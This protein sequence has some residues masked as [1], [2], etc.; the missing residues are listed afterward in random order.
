MK[1][2]FQKKKNKN[3]LWIG[4]HI[5]TIVGKY[6]AQ[7]VSSHTRRI[8][9]IFSVLQNFEYVQDR[10][11]KQGYLESDRKYEANFCRAKKQKRI[12]QHD[13]KLLPEN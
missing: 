4:T 3:L 12:H 6:S 10:L 9:D 11:G 8:A 2:I 1:R 5:L 13:E 7:T